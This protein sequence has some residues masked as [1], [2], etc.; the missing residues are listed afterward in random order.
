MAGR[1]RTLAQMRDEVRQRADIENDPHV[2]DPEIN[3][4]LN[5]SAAALHALL[6]DM[7]EGE[8]V[9]STTIST[10]ANTEGYDLS[11]TN[12]Y[13]LIHVEALVSGFYRSLSRWTFEERTLYRNA[14]TWGWAQIPIAYR[15]IHDSV[16]GIPRIVFAP[17]PNGVYQVTIYFVTGF[18]DLVVDSDAYDGRDGWEEWVVL[19]AAI[20][21]NT[22]SE[23]TGAADLSAERDRVF[24]RIRVQ[25]ATPDLDRPARIRDVSAS[26][27]F[28]Y[29]VGS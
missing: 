10:V 14:S 4:Y 13:K 21:C 15:F 3:R 19:D 26:S 23:S 20:K 6:V 29:Q 24:D 18:T 2:S 8:F 27:P 9:T 25:M 12:I 11:T 16:T 7:D 17:A 28:R 5:Q 1:T 22:K